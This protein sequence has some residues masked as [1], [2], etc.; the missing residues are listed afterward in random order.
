MPLSMD[1]FVEKSRP[2]VPVCPVARV[3]ASLPPKDR[4][5]LVAALGNKDITHAAIAAVLTENGHKMAQDAM[6][7]HRRGSCGCA[8]R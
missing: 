7:R 3:L 1:A 6:G 8:R 5:V 4:D 2:T